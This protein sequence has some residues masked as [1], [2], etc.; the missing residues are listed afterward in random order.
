MCQN[1]SQCP[2]S[3]CTR[4]LSPFSRSFLKCR[5]SWPFLLLAPSFVVYFYSLPF[6]FGLDEEEQDED[7]ICGP[8]EVYFNMHLGKICQPT[9]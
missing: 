5:K 9:K 1:F 4:I 7:E 2:H 8:C 3:R 6:V